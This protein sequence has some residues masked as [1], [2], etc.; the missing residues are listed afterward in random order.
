[1]FSGVI[2]EIY[3]KVCESTEKKHYELKADIENALHEYNK[4]YRE[5]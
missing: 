2:T 3:K 4:S 5:R 1:M